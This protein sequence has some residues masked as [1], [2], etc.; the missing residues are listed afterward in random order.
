MLQNF[1]REDITL[2]KILYIVKHRFDILRKQLVK[3]LGILKTDQISSH[4][5]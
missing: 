5:T 3:K 1:A 2:Q 4:L